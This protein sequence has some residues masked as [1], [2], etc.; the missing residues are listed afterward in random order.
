MLTMKN[1]HED[2]EELTVYLCPGR[3]EPSSLTTTTTISRWND[4]EEGWVVD[5][6]CDPCVP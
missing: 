4:D 5:G 2:N 1:M 6:C 3:A